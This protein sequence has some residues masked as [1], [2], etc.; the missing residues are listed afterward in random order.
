M[1]GE[2]ETV[3]GERRGETPNA[4]KKH[5]FFS[6]DKKREIEDNSDEIV[7]AEIQSNDGVSGSELW[8]Y[9]IKFSVKIMTGGVR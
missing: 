6:L 7:T 3:V 4:K 8:R 9:F 1:K 5:F 2:G